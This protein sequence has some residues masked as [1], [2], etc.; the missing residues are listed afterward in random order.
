LRILTK[1]EEQLE[2]Q[3]IV[4]FS[5]TRHH[6]VCT[7]KQIRIQRSDIVLSIGCQDKQLPEAQTRQLVHIDYTNPSETSKTQMFSFA[8]GLALRSS[9]VAIDNARNNRF[10]SDFLRGVE[11]ACGK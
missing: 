8:K 11:G 7:W 2:S 5:E 9:L 1:R 4:V 6:F 10:A 3:G